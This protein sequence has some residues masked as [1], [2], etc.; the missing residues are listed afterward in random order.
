MAGGRTIFIIRPS[1]WDFKAAYRAVE[2]GECDCVILPIENSFNGDVG[3][4]LDLAFFGSLFINGVYEAEIVQNLLGVKGAS[5][6]DIRKVVSH[7]Q[8]LA[9][10]APFIR[11][12]GLSQQIAEN[13]AIAAEEVAKKKDIHTAAIASEETAELYGLRILV[14]HINE[15]AL[16]T[17]RFAVLSRSPAVDNAKDK[18][19]ILLFTVRNEAGS[20]AEAINIIG[21]YG[22]N[23]RCLRSRPMKELLWQYYFYV[24]LE[25]DLY[26]D[27]GK[28]MLGEL[29]RCCDRLKVVGSFR[30]PATPGK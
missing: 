1:W 14:R 15:T 21:E 28:R 7:P 12:H 17:T 11:M 2:N 3:N 29:T 27:D 24:E 8:A 16:N 9:Q 4:V 13:T 25:G 18:H 6:Q 5:L 30:Y 26:T 10:C 20:L 22:Y 19:S 23:M